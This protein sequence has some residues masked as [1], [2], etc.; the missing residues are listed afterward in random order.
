MGPIEIDGSDSQ[1]PVEFKNGMPT[2]DDSFNTSHDFAIQCR[3]ENGLEMEVNSRDDNGILFEGTKGRIF[4]NRRKIT[5]TPIEKRWDKD[6]FNDESISELYKGKPYEG[7]K[8]NFLRC[9][10]E[11]GLP[12][13]DVFTHVQAMNTCHLSAIAARLGGKITWDPKNE[14]IV[15]N[16]IAA[17]LLSRTP[18]EGFEIPE[19]AMAESK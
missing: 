7:H 3:F 8:E 17:S 14:Q 1:H 10:A 4:V 11:G 16:D 5:G 2:S 9:I 12:V 13:S 15:G 6:T 18:R 19:V